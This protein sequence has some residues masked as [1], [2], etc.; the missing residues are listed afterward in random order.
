DKPLLWKISTSHVGFKIHEKPLLSTGIL[1]WHIEPEKPIGRPDRR[2][3]ISH[4][5]PCRRH[6]STNLRIYSLRT[7]GGDA[8]PRAKGRHP[9][10]VTRPRTPGR[11][12]GLPGPAP[13]RAGR[14]RTAPG[15]GHR[16]VARGEPAAAG[17]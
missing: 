14:T 11:A 4:Q 2:K 13:G 12:P 7:V 17:G 10:G 15:S 16:P 3:P 1:R 5:T 9:H 8:A 6:S